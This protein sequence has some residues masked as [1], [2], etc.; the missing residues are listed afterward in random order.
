MLTS[1]GRAA[2]V[3]GQFGGGAAIDS[4]HVLDL[5]RS[6]RL[7]RAPRAGKIHG[8]SVNGP[9]RWHAG[10]PGPQRKDVARRRRSWVWLLRD[11]CHLDRCGPDLSGDAGADPVLRSRIPLTVKA[12]WLLSVLANPPSCSSSA[13]SRS[14]SI[15]RQD[16]PRFGGHEVETL[17]GGGETG[18]RKDQVS[19]VFPFFIVPDH[20][21][22]LAIAEWRRGLATNRSE[23]ADR[24]Q[25]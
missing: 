16:Q 2:G 3:A 21:H 12:V 5:R 18:R 24:L 14:P 7:D 4:I 10:F 11:D 17:L 13:S 25:S 15:A 6:P 19:F 8:G 20:H 9:A 1:A 23:S 22:H